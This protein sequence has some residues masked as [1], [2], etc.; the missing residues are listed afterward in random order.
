MLTEPIVETTYTFFI[1]LTFL[2]MFRRSKWCYLAAAMTTMVRYE[3]A[4]LIAGA[5]LMDM[6]E[7]ENKRQRINAFVYSALACIPLALWMLGTYFTWSDQTGHYFNVWKK[8]Y[9]KRF[10]QPVA[11]RTGI[12]LHLKLLW[13]V[14]FRPLL[15][16]VTEIKATFRMTQPTAASTQSIQSL[17]TASKVIF[18]LGT[19]FGTI[20]A[21]VKRNRK[22][23]ALL[24][25]FVPYFLLHASYPYPLQRFHTTIF[26]MAL[27]L[28][29]FGIQSIW[30]L[31][32]G[33]GRVPRPIVSF[34]QVVAGLIA[35]IWLIVLFS[36]VGK[37]SKVSPTSSSLPYV[38]LALLVA[39]F[40]VRVFLYRIPA[41]PREF[42]ILAF[43]ALFV[44]SNQFRLVSLLNDGQ[45]EAEFKRLGEWYAKNAKPED[46]MGLYMASVVRMFAP[47]HAENIVRLPCVYD[48]NGE[49]EGNPEKF[50]EECY[51]Q[52]LTYVVWATREGYGNHA[53][54]KSRKLDVNIGFLRERKDHGSYKYVGQAG[55]G[56]GYVNI[57]RLEKREGPEG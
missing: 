48:A 24:I 47:E 20:Y 19:C 43:V 12:G 6:I 25:F 8:D 18:G 21:L 40:A 17:Y 33:G 57:F 35:L 42:A 50:V 14:T 28:F 32:N 55:A 54:Y 49:P 23:V 37:V 53:L 45:K 16:T 41:I 52:G 11:D 34:L 7:A 22:I 3:A 29:F 1:L 51:R 13:H 26:W 15:T 10:N 27:L 44:V 4:A 36:Y 31:I 56:R 30:Q 38:A 39:F 9:A 5:W 46:K 2:L